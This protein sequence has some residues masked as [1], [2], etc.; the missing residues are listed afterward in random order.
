MIIN[1]TFSLEMRIEKLED[2]TVKAFGGYRLIGS[3][4]RNNITPNNN[5][6]YNRVFY[7]ILVCTFI[8]PSLSLSYLIS[9][10]YFYFLLTHRSTSFSSYRHPSYLGSPG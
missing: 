9:N 8:Q 3:R 2:V 6:T 10:V 1:Y 4:L 7:P 5:D